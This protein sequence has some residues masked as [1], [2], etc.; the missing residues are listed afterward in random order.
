MFINRMGPSIQRAII[1]LQKVMRCRYTLQ[2]GST[3]K[4]YGEEPV[5]KGHTPYKSIYTKHPEPVHL[6][7]Q[8]VG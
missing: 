1:Q 2:H 7:T 4:T 3:L 8:K 6:L 5:T